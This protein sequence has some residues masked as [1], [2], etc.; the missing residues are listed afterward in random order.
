MTEA[1]PVLRL[2]GVSF[3][4]PV[5]GGRGDRERWL[6]NELDLEVRP[7]AR[8][9]IV[10]DNGCGK[11]TIAKLVLGLL[12]PDAGR[13]EL[14]GAEVS[15]L[16]NYPSLGYVGDPAHN[17]DELGLPV[18]MTLGELTD[19]FAHLWAGAEPLVRAAEL[20]DA[21]ELDALRDRFVEDL[22]TGER[23]RLM[24]F[25]A[26]AKPARFLLMDE[27]LDG[28][29]RNVRRR[30]VALL[31]CALER[32]GVALL[33]ISHSPAEIAVFTDEVWELRGGALVRQDPRHLQV[34]FERGGVQVEETWT[35]GYMQFMLGELFGD[36]VAEELPPMIQIS[37]ILDGV[38]R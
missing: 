9:G 21:L 10:G 2:D 37:R 13:V 7:A 24:A 16:G 18:G 6:L 36:E 5:A 4:Y 23:K 1:P 15:R 19:T 33:Y 8:I 26:L 20:W 35:F 11:S 28:L 3:C 17:A 29:D 31:R 30:V 25:L 12:A 38:T 27:P 14:F 34:N 22:S 32:S